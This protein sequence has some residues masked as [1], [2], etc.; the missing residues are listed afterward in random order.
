MGGSKKM[1]TLKTKNMKSDKKQVLFYT[2]IHS[3][4]F[5]IL[6]ISCYSQDYKPYVYQ[7][8]TNINDEISVGTLDEVGI[9]TQLVTKGINRILSGRHGEI[10]SLLMYKDGK[11]VLEEYFEGSK[12]KWDAP[13]H[14]GEWVSWKPDMLHRIHSDTKSITAICIGIAIDQG[15]IGS[16]DQSIFDYLPDHQHLKKDGKE[17]ITIE[18]LLTM[19]SGLHWYEW[20]APY[21][22]AENPIIGIWYSDL[23]PVSFI[24]NGSLEHAPGTHYSYYGGHQILLGEILKYASGMTIDEF[25]KQ[26]LFEPLAIDTVNWSTKF[27]DGVFEAAG[28]LEMR[29]RDMAKVGITF[30]NDGVWQSTQILDKHW[31]QKTANPYPGNERINVP[32][33]DE[34]RV[35]YSYSWWT[36]SITDGSKSSNIYWA[37]GWGGQRILVAPEYNTVIVF[38]GGSYLSKV[39]QMKLVEKYLL[40]ALNSKI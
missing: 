28:G 14:R 27:E 30:L 16:V 20:G 33:T 1:V 25:S 8:P 13:G 17:K 5:S 31:I 2:M 21:S 9:N 23:D 39:K 29:P 19:T 40:P 22:S 26:Y 24:L 32:G 36:K 3:I 35:G 7:S 15:F 10:H 37:G 12:F 6:L 38:T 4:L 18:H 34:R 11:L